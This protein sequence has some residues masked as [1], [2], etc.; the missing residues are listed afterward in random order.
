[1]QSTADKNKHIHKHK[2]GETQTRGENEIS[3]SSNTASHIRTHWKK[4][5]KDYNILHKTYCMYLNTTTYMVSIKQIV[6]QGI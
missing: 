5:A 4:H 6:T 2:H 3:K 1:M